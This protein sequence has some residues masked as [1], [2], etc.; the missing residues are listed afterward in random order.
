MKFA[1]ALVEHTGEVT[2]A[3]IQEVRNAG[4]TE[5]DIVEIIAHVGLNLVSNIVGKASRVEIDFP[6]AA[7]K[8]AA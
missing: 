2:T 8:A 6:K 7:L 1:R 4:Y 3:E 5:A